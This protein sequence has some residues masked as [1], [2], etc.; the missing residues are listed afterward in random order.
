[1]PL[2]AANILEAKIRELLALVKHLEAENSRL[3]GEL[4]RSKTAPQTPPETLLELAKA[5]EQLSKLKTER[6]ILQS[7]IAA[8]IRKLDEI[9]SP[10][11]GDDDGE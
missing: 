6:S 10:P 5:K 9:T 8:A 4:E 2:I 1:M 3:S 7:K 11:K